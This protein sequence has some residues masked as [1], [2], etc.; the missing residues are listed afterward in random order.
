MGFNANASAIAVIGTHGGI[1]VSATVRT[2]IATVAAYKLGTYGNL[3]NGRVIMTSGGSDRFAKGQRVPFF[4]IAGHRDAGQTEC[5]GN[6]LYAQLPSIRAIA[7]AAAVERTERVW[8]ES[9]HQ[10]PARAW[11]RS[12]R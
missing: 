3:P 9:P 10:A 6:G 12:W 1:G 11:A 5:P 4:R 2:A 8:R 7:G